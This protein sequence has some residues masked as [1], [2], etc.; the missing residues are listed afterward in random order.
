MFLGQVFLRKLA[1]LGKMGI[2][3]TRKEGI[4]IA[5]VRDPCRVLVSAASE[6]FGD[7]CSPARNRAVSSAVAVAE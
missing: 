4:K 6:E 2:L 1:N 5:R 7:G 3:L